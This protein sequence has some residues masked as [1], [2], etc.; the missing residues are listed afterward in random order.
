MRVGIDISS[1]V[2]GRGVSRYTT[3]LTQSLIDLGVSVS[4]YGSSL[5]RR[6]L[7][8]SFGQEMKSISPKTQ[9][10]TSP[11][12]PKVLEKMW[13]YLQ[14]PKIDQLLPEIDLFHS[15]DWLQPPTQKVPLVSTVHDVAI[16]KFPQTAHPKIIKM[17]RDS[18]KILKERQAHLIA[19][20]RT[21]KNDLVNF[22]DYPQYLIHVVHEALPR[23]VVAVSMNMTEDRYERLKQSLNRQKPFLLI[24]GTQEPRKN[25]DR[26]IQ[27]WQPLHKDIDL[28]LVGAEGWG[29][30]QVTTGPQPDN[31]GRVSDEL[32]SVL[33]AEATVFVYPSL[34]E[35]FGLPILESFFHGTPVLTSDNSGMREVAG[36]AA[37]LINPESVEEIRAGITKLLNEDIDAQRKRLQRMMIRL[38]MF[39]WEKVARETV[40][41][42]KQAMQDQDE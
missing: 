1:V 3:N 24:V 35:G 11:Y 40:A 34:Y 13:K 12:P 32:L 16:L 23:E 6:A 29:D 22:L 8:E 19:V 14:W 42:Y 5:R 30:S 20:S 26:L 41:V 28:V 4:L 39:N 10:V 37:E 15:W 2:F 36:N 21:T 7:L 25:L 17:H 18:W 38:Q 27:A 31:L 33:Y 9:V